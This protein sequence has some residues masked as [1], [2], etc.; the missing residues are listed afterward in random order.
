VRQLARIE[1][2]QARLRLIRQKVAGAFPRAARKERVSQ[3]PDAHHHIGVSE[4]H[5]EHIGSFLRAH[6]GDPAIKVDCVHHRE[7]I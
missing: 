2:R 5:P 3:D 6:D 1:R 7:L 4:N